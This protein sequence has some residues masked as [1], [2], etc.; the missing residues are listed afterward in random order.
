MELEPLSETPSAPTI[1]TSLPTFQDLV[2][3]HEK[4][5]DE[6]DEE[7][8]VMDGGEDAVPAWPAPAEPGSVPAQQASAD[9]APLQPTNS[10]VSN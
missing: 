2:H 9:P 7:P 3:Q 6:D 8:I 5:D 10:S 1:P 4:D